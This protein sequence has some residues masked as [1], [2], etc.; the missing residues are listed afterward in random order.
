MSFEIKE[1]PGWWVRLKQGL[2]KSS[3]KIEDGLKTIFVRRKLDEEMLIELEDFLLTTDMG[4]TTVSKVVQNLRAQKM[5]RDISVEEV[6]ISLS[7]TIAEILKPVAQTLSITSSAPHVVLVVG[8]NGSGK[9]TTIGKLAKLWKEQGKAIEIVAGDTFRAAAVEQLQVW[10]NRLGIN[11]VTAA[12][13]TDAAALAY[14]AFEKAKKNRVDVLIID[15]AGRL[16]NKSHLMEELQKIRR[17]PT[18]N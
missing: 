4:V 13:H 8:V 2:K 16:H 3:D 18:K 10:G 5:N 11:V 14:Q 12:Y 7:E 6:K 17:V 9:T 1:N 15:T